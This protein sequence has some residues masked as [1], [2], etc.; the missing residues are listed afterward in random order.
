MSILLK[1][2]AVLNTVYMLELLEEF[3]LK[4]HFVSGSPLDQLHQN[5]RGK[6][7]SVQAAGL[8]FKAFWVI[9]TASNA[10]SP[11]VAFLL[12]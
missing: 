10:L 9:L 7:G 8:F 6:M 4:K 1:G 2:P 5:H 12:R 3:F 11:S